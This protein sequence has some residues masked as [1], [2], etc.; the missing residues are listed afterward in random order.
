MTTEV[1]YAN[2]IAFLD[3]LRGVALFGIL[4]VNVFN[5]GADY[6]AWSGVADQLAWQVKHVF[7]ET[8]FWMLY[9]LLF[10]MGFFLQTQ[11]P[12][13]T[14]ARSLRRLGVLMLLGCLHGLLFEGDIL[15]LYAELGVLLLLL[16]RLP[17]KWLL[18]LALLLALSFPLGHLVGGDRGDDWPAESVV[19][20]GVWLEEDRRDSP[21]V[22]GSFTEVLAYH[23][24][25]L[26]ERFWVDWQ[27]PDSGLLVLACFLIGFC[28]MRGGW[29]AL[30][31][32]MRGPSMSLAL[33]MWLVG[34]SLMGVERYLSVTL[35]YAP[36][37]RSHAT[38]MQVLGGD[39]VYL[40]ATLSLTGAWFFSVWCWAQSRRLV[41]V[42]GLIASAGQMSLTGYLSQTVMFTTVFYGYGLGAAFEWGPAQVVGFAVGVYALQVVLCHCWMQRFRRGPLEWLWRCLTYW[43]WEPMRR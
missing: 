6:P 8:K 41:G 7:F 31:Q 16:Y 35:G 40:V 34:L 3:V 26:P 33:G 28:L 21:L 20:A 30:Q 5:F 10:G 9:S 27:Y 23:A 13:Y 43:R 12:D 4:L 37:E 38:S 24:A 36:F 17:T 25:F 15:M 1:G 22:T 32:L 42:R 39:L 14:M 29:G 18:S 2:R 19:E 11:S